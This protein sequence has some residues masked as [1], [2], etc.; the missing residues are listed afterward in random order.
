MCSSD[1]ILQLPSM[2]SRLDRLAG[3]SWTMAILHIPWQ[4]APYIAW[5]SFGHASLAR[6]RRPPVNPSSTGTTM[7]GQALPSLIADA[8]PPRAPATLPLS[9]DIE[10]R[11]GW[12]CVRTVA[13]P[14]GSTS[15]ID[16]GNPVEMTGRDSCHP[17]LHCLTGPVGRVRKWGLPLSSVFHLAHSSL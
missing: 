12:G 14:S 3:V 8:C 16:T 11:N 17:P 13:L 6:C 4:L 9:L 5:A 7:R 2:R 15:N 1:L 10:H